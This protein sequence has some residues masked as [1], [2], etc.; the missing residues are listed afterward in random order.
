MFLVRIVSLRIVSYAG[1]CGWWLSRCLCVSQLFFFISLLFTFVHCLNEDLCLCGVFAY[2]WR[3]SYERNSDIRYTMYIV[4]VLQVPFLRCY[5]FSIQHSL[6]PNFMTFYSHLD[7]FYFSVPN[8]TNHSRWSFLA[9]LSLFHLNNRR[10][11]RIT[12]PLPCFPYLRCESK[13]SNHRYS[14]LAPAT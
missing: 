6:R 13:S 1:K 11:N 10:L 3:I 9:S 12:F 7:G 4:S 14:T 8:N 5:A 2:Y